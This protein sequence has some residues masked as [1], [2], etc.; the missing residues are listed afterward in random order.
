M[1]DIKLKD[2]DI[3][4]ISGSDLFN[5][6]ESFMMELTDKDESSILGGI[7]YP[8]TKADIEC[9]ITKPPKCH[10]NTCY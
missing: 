10:A 2:L 9:D 3:Y 8:A 4:S 1:A 7:C 5:D 6:S